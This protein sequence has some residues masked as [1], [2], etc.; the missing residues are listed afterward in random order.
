MLHEQM[1]DRLVTSSNKTSLWGK[2]SQS[3]TESADVDTTISGVIHRKGYVGSLCWMFDRTMFAHLATP[4]CL[5][6]K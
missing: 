6:Q 1:F 2:S 5:Q 3:E 4:S